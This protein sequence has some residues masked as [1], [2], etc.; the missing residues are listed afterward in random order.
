MMIPSCITLTVSL[1]P[2]IIPSQAPTDLVAQ[3]LAK[4]DEWRFDSF[5]LDRVTDGRPLSVMAFAVLKK[6]DLVPGRWDKV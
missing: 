6:C 2:L 4:M 5:E 1:R 3:C